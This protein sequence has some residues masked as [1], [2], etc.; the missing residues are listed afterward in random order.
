MKKLIKELKEL[1]EQWGCDGDA[2]MMD[3]YNND[4]DNHFDA[5]FKKYESLVKHKD[6]DTAYNGDYYKCH[7]VAIVDLDNKLHLILV[8]VEGC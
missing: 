1:S 7:A 3:K 5:I 4:I 2:S 8:E 6:I